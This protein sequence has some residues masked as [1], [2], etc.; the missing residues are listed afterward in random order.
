VIIAPGASTSRKLAE[1]EKQ[2]TLS[3]AVVA[4]LHPVHPTLP[5]LL[6]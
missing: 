4:S 1:F 6:S 2:V 3:A 5:K